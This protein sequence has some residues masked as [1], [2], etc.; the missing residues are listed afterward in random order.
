MTQSLKTRDQKRKET[1]TKI[2][3]VT[4]DRVSVDGF[5]GV[6][7]YDIARDAGVS[8]GTVFLHYPTKEKL[9]TSAM[10]K[11]A[12]DVTTRMRKLTNC[13]M[14]LKSLLLAHLDVLCEFEDIYTKFIA[15]TPHMS[16]EMR[17]TLITVQGAISHTLYVT[18]KRE[19]EKGVIKPF[20]MDMLF[21]S[22]IGLV[23]HYL[24]NKELFAP[25]RSV[26]KERGNSLVDHFFEMVK[27]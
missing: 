21:N 8:H 10:M 11:F 12:D 25:G 5:M 24:L 2:L 16:E 9:I 1:Q 20:P 19:I 7:T 3:R 6:N 18:A 13:D 15:E 17:V 14:G 26:I 27:K 23:H 22:W 4:L